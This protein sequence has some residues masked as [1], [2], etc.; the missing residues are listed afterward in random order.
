MTVPSATYRLQ[1][2]EHL[3][4]RKAG[5]L[6]PYLRKLGV[7]HLYLSPIF[8]AMPEST[9]GYDGIDFNRID[10]SLGGEEGYGDLCRRA[11]GLGLIIDLVPNHMAAST[12]NSWWKDV[13]EW[14]QTSHYAGHFDIDWTAPKLLLPF[15]GEPYGDVIARGQLNLVF[16][17]RAGCFG[18]RYFDR[19][20]PLSPP[21]YGTILARSSS[22]ML[23]NL[24]T[25]FSACDAVT[26][27]ALKKRLA[28]HSAN[29]LEEGIHT[30]VLA[31][32]ND[33]RMIHRL[34]ERQ[35]W[36][37][38]WWRLARE[39]LTYR[40]FFEI[41]DL[42]GVR[43]EEPHVFDDVH[44][45]IFSL[46][47]AGFIDG[48]RIDHIDGLANPLAYLDRLREKTDCYLV[49]EKILG[50]DESLPP[51][52][53]VAGT[54]GYEFIRELTGVF[55][56]PGGYRELMST[57]ADFIGDDNMNFNAADVK[58]G[59]FTHNFASELSKLVSV[60]A[61]IARNDTCTRDI[62]ED[63]LREAIV[64]MASALPVYRTYVAES[65]PGPVDVALIDASARDTIR[66]RNADG[67]AVAFIRRLL[68]LDCS[69]PE[70]RDKAL[71]FTRRFQQATGPL[72][73]KAVEDTLFYRENGLI[74]V[75]EVGS[76]PETSESVASF[77]RAMKRQARNHPTQLNATSTHDTKRGED[78]RAR[79][80][81][82][83][84]CAGEWAAAVQRWSGMNERFRMHLADGITPDASME[85][86]F[87]QTLL[88]AWPMQLAPA[89]GKE[90]R[91]LRQRVAAAMQKAAREA[92]LRTSWTRPD[93][94]YET[95]LG[96]FIEQ[97]LDVELSREF[98]ADFT[99]VADPLLVGGALTSLTQALLK[100]IA[101]GVPDIYQGAELWDLSMVDPDNRRAVDFAG[102]RELLDRV[103]HTSPEDLV[104]DWRNGAIKMRVVADGLRL[105]R[106]IAGWERAAFIECPVRGEQRSH[107]VAF[108]RTFDDC[109]IV[110][111]GVSLPQRLLGE[112]TVPHVPEV[113]WRD[114]TLE[115]P[116]GQAAS[117]LVNV[118]TGDDLDSNRPISL[119]CLLRRF[120]VA[121]LSSPRAGQP[122]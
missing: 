99:R 2:R 21:S 118:F 26:A 100:V 22:D 105:R 97:V 90:L 48:I 59:M 53:P 13:L 33:L 47:D 11:A 94:E 54:T 12:L 41:A 67:E 91:A 96:S 28:A 119:S 8:A 51:S 36:R 23:V 63:A 25:E 121:L 64:G 108:C 32:Q 45:E 37:L 102:R 113:A 95:A 49:V 10:A 92:K 15:L 7:S 101:P 109:T 18:L 17:A 20:Y 116:D 35:P 72:T 56:E 80:Y 40:R 76:G 70:Q 34:H 9:H 110:A 16:D 68:M 44:R 46:L 84:E 65:G 30:L 79:L 87:Y 24:A 98:L 111:I 86:Y 71:N 103:G 89:D 50:R 117:R 27:P 69:T 5:E 115:L 88:G 83:S 31:F 112:S 4:F 104:R 3:D 75:N 81:G 93:R 58:R 66:C 114:T 57:F 120:P 78:A 82:L 85:W 39:A 6:V 73:A 52:W 106:D 1:L 42:V 43:V 107:V 62:G 60:A 19:T 29:G 61:A 77:Y 14:G 38:A 74:A 55:V 122:S